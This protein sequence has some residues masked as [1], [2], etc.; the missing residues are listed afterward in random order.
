MQA[1]IVLDDNSS[2]SESTDNGYRAGGRQH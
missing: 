2:R 1:C